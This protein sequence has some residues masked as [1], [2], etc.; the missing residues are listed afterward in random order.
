MSWEGWSGNPSNT[1]YRKTHVH[2]MEVEIGE[3]GNSTYISL[4]AGQLL[5]LNPIKVFYL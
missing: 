1:R 2:T 3:Y 5:T 4:G